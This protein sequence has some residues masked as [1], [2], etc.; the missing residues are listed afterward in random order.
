MIQGLDKKLN[1]NRK[2]FE[3]GKA[4]LRKLDDDRKIYDAIMET[5]R[6]G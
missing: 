6:A 4:L 2:K 5:E 1:A 3:N